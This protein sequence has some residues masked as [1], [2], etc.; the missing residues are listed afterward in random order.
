V[1]ALRPAIFLDRDGTVIEDRGYL[2][3]PDGVTLL[4]GAAEAIADLNRAGWPVVIVTN[5][6]GIGRGYYGEAQYRAIQRRLDALLEEAGA[7]VLATY[8][9]PHAPDLVPPCDCRK[10]RPG[11]FRTAAREHGLD[12]ARSVYIGDRIRDIEPGVTMGGRGFLVCADPDP[13]LSLP[14]GVR[15]VRSLREAADDLVPQRSPD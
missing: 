6:S 10:P 8:H 3:D 1:T 7:T 14:S 15:R 12:L 13:K 11:L 9:C 4:E 2:A 5:Q